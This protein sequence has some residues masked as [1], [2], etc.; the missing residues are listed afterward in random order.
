MFHCEFIENESEVEVMLNGTLDIQV[1]LKDTANQYRD[2]LHY[3]RVT[4]NFR[5]IEAVD[6]TGL[7]YFLQ[8]VDYLK[9]EKIDVKVV[10]VS[11]HL[12]EVF[13]ILQFPK[14]LGEQIYQVNY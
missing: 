2:L 9:D 8:V 4:M 12:K 7:E 5:G 3:K 14:I 1:K 10:E 11:N 6:A 13:D